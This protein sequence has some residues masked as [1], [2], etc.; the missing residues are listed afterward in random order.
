[1][2]NIVE[3]KKLLTCLTFNKSLRGSRVRGFTLIELLVVVSI[4]GLLSSVVLV[5]VKSAREKAV[6]AKTVAEMKSLQQAIEMYRNQFGFYPDEDGS[7]SSE[8]YDFYGFD[9]AGS[10][11]SSTPIINNMET[12][13]KVKLVDNKLLAKV[14]H[15]PNYPNNCKSNKNCDYVLGYSIY[16]VNNNGFYKN[17]PSGSYV[18]P[19]TCG[20]KKIENYFIYF[21]T[22]KKV[23]LPLLEVNYPSLGHPDG[24][25]PFS[26][27][28]GIS[29]NPYIYCI[30]G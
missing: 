11:F 20:R 9:D 14:P 21:L 3:Y 23:N 4:I 16:D 8:F 15:A 26:S 2:K 29:G 24:Y 27:Y 28:N 7:Y 18:Y 12:F 25:W 5:S 17:I 6:L 30:A 10:V 22:Y 19:V 13:F 1:M